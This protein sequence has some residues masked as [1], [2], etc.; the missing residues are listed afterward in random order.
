MRTTRAL[1]LGMALVAAACSDDDGGA[2][3]G[4]GAGGGAVG[5]PTIELD[6][7]QFVSRLETL[8]DCDA[9]LAH[10]REEAL[11]RVG[12]YGLDGGG[13][14]YGPVAEDGAAR[15]MPATTA[16]GGTDDEASAGDGGATDGG[17]STTN[18]AEVGVDEADLVK[19]D[20]RRIYTVHEGELV[21][22]DLTGDAP[23]EAG[24]AKLRDE[25]V[26][27]ELLLA[28]GRVFVVS[29]GGGFAI[30]L[31]TVGVS[32]IMPPYGSP[33]TVVQ[34]FDVADA[35]APRLVRTLTVDGSYV[36]TRVVDGTA[37]LVVSARPGE[38]PFLYPTNPAGEARAE[39]INRQ[40]VRESTLEQWLPAYT[41]E[42]EGGTASGGLL[43][44]CDAVHAPSE[45]AGFG[46]TAVISFGLAEGPTD[47]A[48]GSV[49][50][51]APGTWVYASPDNL[52]VATASY[53]PP[54]AFEQQD[55]D[56]RAMDER[57]GTSIH[58]FAAGSGAAVYEASG[59]V[60]GHLLGDLSLSEHEGDLRVATTVGS[61]WSA[62]SSESV[63]TVLRR[64]GDELVR[65]GQVGGLGE[66]EQI[67]GVRFLGDTAYVVTFRQIDPFYVV[68]LADP[69]APVVRGEL[70]MPGYSGYLHA[71]G[72]GRVLGVGQE[73][74]AGG[75]LTGLKVSLFDVSDPGA[76]V[77]V[78]TWT[79]GGRGTQSIVEFDRKA[80]LWWEPEQLA[81]VPV[82]DWEG[83]FNGVVL[84]RV[85]PDGLTEAGRIEHRHE[86]GGQPR[87]DVIDPKRLDRLGYYP[88]DGTI[89]Q[90]CGP[91]QEPG[92]RGYDCYQPPLEELQAYAGEALGELAPGS[93]VEICTPP[94]GDADPIQRTLVVGDDLWT[95]G[96]RYL[97]ADSLDGLNRVA[98]IDL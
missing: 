70:K 67:R 20:G 25:I 76:P 88:G 65:V 29:T 59:T 69:A 53:I 55:W 45:F 89:V 87:C 31:D 73:G 35:D 58:R 40:V 56:Q 81:A 42:P 5:G 27:G 61:P 28:D 23:R 84:V 54:E 80:F 82:N 9:L 1:L 98:R 17:F 2:A 83:G 52:Y 39:E 24:R 47:P 14:W 4:T 18:T 21:V 12:P 91:D 50:V 90:V 62:E 60:P 38:L 94:Y 15:P 43:L 19:T 41:L 6:D 93:V 8:G 30:P 66:G 75:Q 72:D 79:Y 32:R 7:L 16:A 95:L 22:V 78:D 37:R 44:P 64:D 97:Q 63:I 13:G 68:D 36:S 10:L 33:T 71:V 57:Y 46:T 26:Q 11:A 96:Y 77:E 51:L 3:P 34:E 85:G 74:T 49:G 86:G 92:I 48:T